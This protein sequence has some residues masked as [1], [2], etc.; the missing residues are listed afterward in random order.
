MSLI[1]YLFSFEGGERSAGD[2]RKL[3]GAFLI[4]SFTRILGLNI[5]GAHNEILD[6]AVLYVADS[7]M[8][9]RQQGG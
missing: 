3:I 5:S 8:S 9:K 4:V 7:R 6:R 2:S 1:G